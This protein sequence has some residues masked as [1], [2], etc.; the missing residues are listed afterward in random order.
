MGKVVCIHSTYTD[1]YR[2]VV[3]QGHLAQA[4]GLGGHNYSLIQ[5]KDCNN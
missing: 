1:Q 5:F 3:Q 2:A 4:T